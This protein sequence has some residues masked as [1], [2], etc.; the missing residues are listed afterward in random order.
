MMKPKTYEAYF[1][2]RAEAERGMV[3]PLNTYYLNGSSCCLPCR[4]HID[5]HSRLVVE[6]GKTRQKNGRARK[7]ILPPECCDFC[8]RT[9][10]D[11]ALVKFGVMT[12]VR[13]QKHLLEGDLER[14]T[15]ETY[16]RLR[17]ALE[18]A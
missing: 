5:G 17:K 16:S 15:N 18:S 14:R 2:K 3:G 11:E 4:R 12:V 6:N 13:E 9:P 8:G 10:L 1:L 7:P